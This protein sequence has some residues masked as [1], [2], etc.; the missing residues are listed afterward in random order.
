MS[1]RGY[2]EELHASPGCRRLENNMSCFLFIFVGGD[3][4][5]LPIANTRRTPGLQDVIQSMGCCG[6]LPFLS[7]GSV[8]VKGPLSITDILQRG[9]H[10]LPRWRLGK[11]IWVLMMIFALNR[12]FPT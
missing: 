3:V 5:F 9:Q 8:M 6:V 12:R 10:H 4:S 11:A 7:K 1:C 2:L